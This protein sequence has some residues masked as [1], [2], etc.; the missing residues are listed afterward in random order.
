MKEQLS[1]L[2]LANWKP[3]AASDAFPDQDDCAREVD[4]V[5]GDYVCKPNELVSAYDR[6]GQ[7]IRK[8]FHTMLEEVFEELDGD[9][10]TYDEVEYIAKACG[11][12]PHAVRDWCELAL[13]LLRAQCELKFC[14]VIVRSKNNAGIALNIR[15]ALIV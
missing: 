7:E 1:L 2:A 15:T 11:L 10:P 13:S 5:D 14:V 9:D 4:S 12:L 6:H 3:Q 8:K